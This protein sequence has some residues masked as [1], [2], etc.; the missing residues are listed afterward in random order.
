MSAHNLLHVF[1]YLIFGIVLIVA[2]AWSLLNEIIY[3]LFR[4][5]EWYAVRLFT[6]ILSVFLICLGIAVV[7]DT[8]LHLT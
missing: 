8:I 6:A 5:T 3:D 7:Y 2:G 1:I 4:T